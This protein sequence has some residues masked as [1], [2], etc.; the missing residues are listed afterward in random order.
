MEND[1]S[2]RTCFGARRTVRS[3]SNVQIR[4]VRKETGFLANSK[5]HLENFEQ[6]MW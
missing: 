4:D 2:A 3:G 1:V 5:A 6:Q